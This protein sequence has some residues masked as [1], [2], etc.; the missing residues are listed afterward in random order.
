MEG[1]REKGGGKEGERR[2]KEGEREGGNKKEGREGGREGVRGREKI[3]KG[4]G[5]RGVSKQDT[6]ISL[7]CHI[8]VHNYF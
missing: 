3:F 7:K 2:G 4:K 6:S 5:E 1:W 8:C